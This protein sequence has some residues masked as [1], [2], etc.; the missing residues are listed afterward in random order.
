MTAAK[1]YPCPS[2]GTQFKRA[3]GF[4]RCCTNRCVNE[5]N[6]RL[7]FHRNLNTRLMALCAEALALSST[8]L[9]SVMRQRREPGQESYGQQW[10]DENARVASQL[11]GIVANPGHRFSP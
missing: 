6:Q 3:E 2:C 7:R 10:I 1:M 4:G 8:A 11:E 9:A 5:Y